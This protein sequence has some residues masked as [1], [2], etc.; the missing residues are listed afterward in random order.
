VYY[1]RNISR[2]EDIGLKREEVERA[3]VKNRWLLEYTDPEDKFLLKLAFFIRFFTK[4]PYTP[5]ILYE[6]RG[7]NKKVLAMGKRLL[8][9]LLPCLPSYP[10]C[11]ESVSEF[12]K[13]SFREFLNIRKEF[14]SPHEFITLVKAGSGNLSFLH[15]VM[16]MDFLFCKEDKL[17]AGVIY[18]KKCSCLYLEV[19]VD[20][21]TKD[22]YLFG[23]EREKI[24]KAIS[25]FI[26]TADNVFSLPSWQSLKEYFMST[27][28][29]HAPTILGIKRE[30]FL[31]LLQLERFYRV[32]RESRSLREIQKYPIEFSSFILTAYAKLIEHF[33]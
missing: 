4:H 13:E 22:S 30:D 33:L 18:F 29:L 9:S 8:P 6:G 14:L 23:G 21:R 19:R 20:S 28:S 11:E 16:E 7:D 3:V 15:S 31:F 27:D 32:I 25:S 10:G 24:E 1:E 26:R 2:L 17:F 5:K 12:M